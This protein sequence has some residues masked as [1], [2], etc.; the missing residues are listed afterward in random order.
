MKIAQAFV[1]SKRL[2]VRAAATNKKVSGYPARFGAK[3][4]AVGEVETFATKSRLQQ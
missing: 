4:L 3:S 1:L 2:T